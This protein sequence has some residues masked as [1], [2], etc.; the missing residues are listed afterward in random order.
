MRKGLRKQ[1]IS[2]IVL[3]FLLFFSISCEEE[4]TEKTYESLEGIYRC[5]EN[6]PY[7]GH[8]KY[9]VEIDQVNDQENLFIIS[10]FHNQGNAEFIYANRQNDSVLLIE[11]Q[12]ISNLYI[13]GEGT[14]NNGLNEVKMI[15]TVDDASM[16]V[17][18]YAL[19]SR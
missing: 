10:N 17:E 14:V 16:E 19:Y 7:T 2:N 15:Y 5:E 11:N 12:L 18:Y 3:L 8:R 13:H 4:K 9:I 1:K 6:S